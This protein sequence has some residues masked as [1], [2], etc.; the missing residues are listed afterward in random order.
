MA[1]LAT[2]QGLMSSAWAIAGLVG[3][4]FSLFIMKAFNLNSLY[5]SLAV[6]YAIEAIILLIWIKTAINKNRLTV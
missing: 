3:N 4:K 2:V 5:T 1:Q 6:I